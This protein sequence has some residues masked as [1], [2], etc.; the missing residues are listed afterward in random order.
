[1]VFQSYALY[2]NKTVR[3]NIAFPLA[4]RRTPREEIARSLRRAVVAS[5]DEMAMTRA[6]LNPNISLAV[7]DTIMV[8]DRGEPLYHI[9]HV[10]DQWVLTGKV[11][12]ISYPIPLV[13]GST[14]QQDP[15]DQSSASCHQC[16]MYDRSST[17]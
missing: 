6:N 12:G 5:E 9:Q 13:Q 16:H 4:L 17:P 11:T 15:N 10:D 8:T 7:G 1:M 3:E 14:C 2:P